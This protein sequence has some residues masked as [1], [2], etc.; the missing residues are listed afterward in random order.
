MLTRRGASPKLQLLVLVTSL[1]ETSCGRDTQANE[2]FPLISKEQDYRSIGHPCRFKSCISERHPHT[3]AFC[4]LIRSGF[5]AM[6]VV[7][8]L[9]NFPPFVAR[10]RHVRACA[11]SPDRQPATI[12]C[13]NEWPGNKTSKSS[14]RSANA[15]SIWS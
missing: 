15:P 5:L 10:P 2:G 1:D 8:G 7:S 11:H 9:R 3:G 6:L 14:Q 13:R 4:F 12:D